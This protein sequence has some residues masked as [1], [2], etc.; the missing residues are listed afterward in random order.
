MKRVLRLFSRLLFYFVGIFVVLL[1]VVTLVCQHPQVKKGIFSFFSHQFEA[2][3]GWHL[4]AKNISGFLPFYL[5]AEQLRFKTAEGEKI[6]CDCLSAFFSPIDLLRG[7]LSFPY[8]SF[9]GLPVK[10]HSINCEGKCEFSLIAQTGSI[11]ALLEFPSMHLAPLSITI[12]TSFH[13]K[14]FNLQLE[15]AQRPEVFLKGDLHCTTRKDHLWLDGCLTLNAL[16]L[17]PVLGALDF[18][19]TG[20]AAAELKVSGP[21]THP[22]FDIALY[23]SRLKYANI[24]TSGLSISGLVEWNETGL[25]GPCFIKGNVL[26]Q[27]LTV[28]SL[29]SW[30]P[31][32]GISLQHLNGNWESLNF[33]GNLGMNSETCLLLGSLEGEIT[34]LTPFSRFVSFPLEGD[35]GVKAEFS[36]NE[37]HKQAL[38]IYCNAEN[39]QASVWTLD[40]LQIRGELEDVLECPIGKWDG[41][42]NNLSNGSLNWKSMILASD[43]DANEDLW[44]FSLTGTGNWKS[45]LF[46][47]ASGEWRCDWDG[48]DLK[49]DLLDG[50][51]QN[52]AIQLNRSAQLNL[53]PDHFAL[54]PLYIEV[55]TGHFFAE[56][57]TE[58]GQVNGQLRI[59]KIPVETLCTTLL[60]SYH[61]E[62]FLSAHAKLR[63]SPQNLEGDCT[64]F[65]EDMVIKEN[66]FADLPPFESQLDV[67]LNSHNLSVR[68]F[69]SCEN[70][71]PAYCEWELPLTVA[72]A[73]AITTTLHNDRELKGAVYI[74]GEV[75]PILQLLVTDTT[76]IAGYIKAQ[77]DISGTWSRPKV[78]GNAEIIDGTFESLDTGAIISRINARCEG[79]D[80][81][82]TL[83]RFEALSGA[84]G[85]IT[86]SGKCL[87]DVEQGFPFELEAYLDKT[88]LIRLDYAQATGSGFLRLKGNR[89]KATLGGEIV[90]DRGVVRIPDQMPV[91]IQTVEVTYVSHNGQKDLKYLSNEKK[92]SWPIELNIYLNMPG[93]AFVNGRNLTSEWGGEVHFSG[94]SHQ[95]L[96]YGIMK[97]MRGEYLFN[98]RPFTGSAGTITFNGDPRKKASL[99]VIAE[100]DLE[101][102]RAEAILKGSLENPD[103]AFRS[104]PP[105]PEREILSW[106]LFSR[107][108]SE[109]SSFQQGELNRS[110]FTLSAGRDENDVLSIIRSGIGIDRVDISNVESRGDSQLSLRI[111]KYLTP[112]VFISLNKSLH[113]DCN[114]I[115]LE[116]SFTNDIKAQVEIGDDR[117]GKI[118]LKWE[119]DY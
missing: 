45:P 70:E 80:D 25:I 92:E 113:N 58:G 49:L 78:M 99:Y 55:G 40:S 102:I 111:G 109:I 108:T 14:G 89:S 63:G 33:Y 48:L 103:L 106:I 21:A 8:V 65:L 15:G 2:K 26:H 5:R 39:L 76:N 101:E 31:S 17:E 87:V 64:V 74:Q 24:A 4:K 83:T 57:K 97:L 91:P 29:I 93:R 12:N 10:G 118:N 36:S 59:D 73:P 94:T 100:R 37:N 105:L 30:S 56:A 77:A 79:K 11:E 23:S 71:K 46:F 22:T 41:T 82:I 16:D 96:L 13:D 38:K 60:P 3:T 69:I 84:E 90:L 110:E 112:G 116:A 85:S 114:Q 44:P 75:A 53:K 98:G 117:E 47:T 51:T 20:M 42:I 68:G 72:L 6:Q 1:G 9:Q 32:N 34:S 28:S 95:P 7:N 52:L 104:N 86:A 88:N 67:H 62:G 27:P 35:I 43:I 119:R 18:P 54:S 19:I 66:I 61:T 115:A 50:G 107:G 81:T